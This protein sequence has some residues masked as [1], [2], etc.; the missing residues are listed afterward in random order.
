MRHL[1]LGDPA[2]LRVVMQHYPDQIRRTQDLKPDIVLAGHTHGGQVCLPGG[3]PIIKHDSLPRLYTSG[4][5]R[6]GDVWL[7][8]GRGFGFSTL[9]V[10]AFCPPQVVE[11][12]LQAAV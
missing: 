12:V 6:Y 11:I 9:P 3:F 4:V 5:H 2:R 7:I 8:V 1:R 10:R